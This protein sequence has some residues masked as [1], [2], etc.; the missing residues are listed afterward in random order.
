LLARTKM[1]RE[2]WR[3]VS[4]PTEINNSFNSRCSRSLSKIQG[5]FQIPEVKVGA[6]T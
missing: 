4:Q 3:G 5:S 6:T 1:F 2:I